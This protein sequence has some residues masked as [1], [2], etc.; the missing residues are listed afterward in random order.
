ME[1]VISIELLPLNFRCAAMLAT[2]APGS[3]YK[4][5]A[6]SDSFTQLDRNKRGL[7]H[8]AAF[9]KKNDLLRDIIKASPGE[10][11]LV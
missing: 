9:S 7:A 2:T 3:A 4:I 8:R 1:K 6:T 11:K 5:L 10:V